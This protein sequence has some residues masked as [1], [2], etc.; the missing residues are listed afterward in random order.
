MNKIHNFINGKIVESESKEF[1]PVF[2]P[3]TGEVIA[4]VVQ[5]TEADIEAAVAA[6]KAAFPA[7]ANTSPLKRSRIMNKF[8]QFLEDNLDELAA[9][10]SRAPIRWSSC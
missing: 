9:I 8:R 7:W 5:S 1:S 2:N 10:I 6:A 4:E 3:A